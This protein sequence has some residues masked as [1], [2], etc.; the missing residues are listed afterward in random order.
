MAEFCKESGTVVMHDKGL[1]EHANKGKDTLPSKTKPASSA[2][3][4]L[5]RMLRRRLVAR[6][7]KDERRLWL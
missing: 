4:R 1:K 7:E 5:Q 6:C 2:F 3:R